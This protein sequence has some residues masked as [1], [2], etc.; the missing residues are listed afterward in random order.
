MTPDHTSRETPTAASFHAT[1]SPELSQYV[2]RRGALEIV[3]TRMW[4]TDDAHTRAVALCAT[5]NRMY[6]DSTSTPEPGAQDALCVRAE[7]MQRCSY[8]RCDCAQG[9][10]PVDI[11]LRER[12]SARYAN[13]SVQLTDLRE[14][15]GAEF[16]GEEG[17]CQ[18]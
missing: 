4:G 9:A 1:Y 10:V 8:P 7:L 6:M 15:D 2:V 17:Q 11:V 14:A 5:L 13:V 16:A 3:P 12:T 18:A